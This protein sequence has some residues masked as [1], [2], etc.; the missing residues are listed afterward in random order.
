MLIW[1]KFFTLFFFANAIRFLIFDTFC[2][3]ASWIGKLKSIAAA[4]FMIVS[5]FIDSF[6]SLD[7]LSYLSN[8]D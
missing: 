6:V 5:I 4:Q 1:I 8:S 2:S 3:S 7:V